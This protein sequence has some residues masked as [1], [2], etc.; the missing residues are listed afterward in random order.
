MHT[1]RKFRNNEYFGSVL[2]LT[3]ENSTK[4]C[5]H[6]V[7]RRKIQHS[8]ST[9]TKNKI[10]KTESCRYCS[11][12]S[13]SSYCVRYLILI[14]QISLKICFINRRKHRASMG[15][16]VIILF[17]KDSYSVCVKSFWLV[18]ISAA[19]WVAIVPMAIVSTWR[20]RCCSRSEQ[21][22][23]RSYRAGK[24]VGRNDFCLSVAWMR[25]QYETKRLESSN[26]SNTWIW[27]FWP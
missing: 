10:K 24:Q 12:F 26:T 22:T 17:W 14:L 1:A 11:T 19:Q 5:K 8:N 15:D 4:W 7:L 2:Y 16:L 25:G 23:R 18:D 6:K 3:D 9:E 21:R 27:T 13:S 20:R